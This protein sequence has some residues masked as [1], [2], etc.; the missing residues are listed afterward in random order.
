MRGADAEL[1]AAIRSGQPDGP[2]RLWTR[3]APLVSRILRR[4]FAPDDAE[5]LAQEVF[6]IVFRKLPELREPRALKAFIFSTTVLT[7]RQEVRRRGVRRR[8]TAIDDH[9]PIMLNSMHRDFDAREALHRLHGVLNRLKARDRKAFVLRFIEAMNVLDVAS[10]LRVSLATAKR[11]L[12]RGSARLILLAQRDP[13]LA[14]YMS[15]PRGEE[16]P[17]DRDGR[18]A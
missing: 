4:S 9:A 3:Y 7:V 8:A 11:C 6:L 12:V 15:P 5:D 2:R 16:R 18:A 1:V 17:D 13:L 14:E 10:V